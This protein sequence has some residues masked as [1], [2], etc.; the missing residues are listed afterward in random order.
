MSKFLEKLDIPDT[1]SLLVRI[2][3]RWAGH[4]ARMKDDCI[5]KILL[6]GQKVE[7]FNSQRRPLLRYKTNL[8]QSLRSRPGKV[9]AWIDQSGVK[10]DLDASEQFKLKKWN[11]DE[12]YPETDKHICS[13]VGKNLNHRFVRIMIS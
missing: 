10:C 6:K 3:C 1:E 9:V 11:N 12:L 13:I 8:K 7:G 2:Q 4:G 5:L